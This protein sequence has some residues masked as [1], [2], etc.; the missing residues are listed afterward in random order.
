MS[1]S[2]KSAPT[3]SLAP[4]ASAAS[5]FTQFR[6]T[7]ALWVQR[8]RERAELAQCDERDLLDMGVTRATALAE[9]RKPFWRE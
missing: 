1:I 8:A 5:P 7:V 2:F 6:A 3:V 4:A 9:I